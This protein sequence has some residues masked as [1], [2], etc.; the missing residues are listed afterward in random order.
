LWR[1]E[2]I[3][4][5]KGDLLDV[6]TGPGIIPGIYRKGF[7]VGL[8]I[9][10]SM[11]KRGKRKSVMVLGDGE[12]LPFKDNTFDTITI[13]FGLRNIPDKEKALKEFFRVLRRPGRLIILEMK[14]SPSLI[15]L[16]NLVYF[17]LMVI[18]SPF[19]GGSVKDYI[20]LFKS[21]LGFPKDNVLKDMLLSVGFQRVNV[22]RFAF[23]PTRIFYAEK[24][25]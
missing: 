7:S 25:L 19:F 10:L 15:D 17:A 23:S 13:A 2:V 22:K 5:S 12:E 9:S 4:I 16:P 20:Y 18:L 21:V 14:V 6:A 11:L 1:R 3:N 8:D 24:A